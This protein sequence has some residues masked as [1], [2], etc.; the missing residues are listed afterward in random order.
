MW[1]WIWGLMWGLIPEPWDHDL[2]WRQLFNWLSH[3]E[4]PLEV[5]LSKHSSTS[6]LFGTQTLPFIWVCVCGWGGSCGRIEFPCALFPSGSWL[7]LLSM[8]N[9][10]NDDFASLPPPEAVDLCLDPRDQEGFLPSLCGLRHLH[11]M[12]EGSKKWARFYSSPVLRGLSSI[13]C[14]AP[15]LSQE[16]LV[17]APW[18]RACKWVWTALVFGTRGFDILY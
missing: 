7:L 9:P 11:C 10:A 6:V 2:S 5:G 1:D 12:R 17:E 3:L 16:H 8:E 14:S 13:S 4:V 18:K 15:S